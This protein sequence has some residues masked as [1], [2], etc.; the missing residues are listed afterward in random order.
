NLTLHR[1]L[2]SAYLQLDRIAKGAAHY[3]FCAM[4]LL[5]AGHRRE[6]IEIYR[7]VLKILPTDF[8]TLERCVALIAED[9]APLREPDL[10]VVEQARRLLA[11]YLDTTQDA[12]ALNLAQCLLRLFPDD[13]GL[14]GLVPRL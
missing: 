10:E 3:R 14:L 1:R 13:E 8:R 2:A 12:P 4:A 5:A 11:F 9:E 6:A 7:N